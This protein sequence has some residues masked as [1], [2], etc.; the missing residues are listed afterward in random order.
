MLTCRNTT[1][2]QTT[3]ILQENANLIEKINLLSGDL[4]IKEEKLVIVDEV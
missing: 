1:N 4:L 3:G 2:F